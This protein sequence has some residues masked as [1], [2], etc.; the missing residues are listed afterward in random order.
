MG[1][2]GYRGD[3][4][5]FGGEEGLM[6]FRTPNPVPGRYSGLGEQANLAQLVEHF[7]RNERVVGSIPIVGSR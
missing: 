1:R 5:L 3:L 6:Y 2:E 7:I 4:S